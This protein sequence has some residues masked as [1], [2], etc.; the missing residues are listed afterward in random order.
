[1]LKHSAHYKWSRPLVAETGTAGRSENVEIPINDD[2][3]NDTDD[4]IKSSQPELVLEESAPVNEGLGEEIDINELIIDEPEEFSEEN[5][6][7]LVNAIEVD[8]TPSDEVFEIMDREK[9]YYNLYK[10]ARRRANQ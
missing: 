9:V 1:M 5:E 3:E 7:N 6:Y 8:I 2:P 10:D 4:A